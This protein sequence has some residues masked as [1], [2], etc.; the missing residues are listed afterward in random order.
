MIIN[1]ISVIL[2][3]LS[4]IQ[5]FGQEIDYGGTYSYG[6]NPESGPVGLI[7]VHPNSDS[8]LL[9]YLDLNIGSPS[10]NNGS[11]IGQM[12]IYSPGEA[13]F[14]IVNQNE[15]INCSM[16]FWFTN[17][18]LY[19]RTNDQADDCG[20]G[21]GVYSKGDF[22]R[23]EEDT[24]EFFINRNGKQFWFKDLDWKKWWTSNKNE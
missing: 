14:T 18:S 6:T 20:Y 11:I 8:T 1:R 19:I 16:N 24:P 13:D 5:V 17:D 12:N 9:F 23:I 2:I 4:S 3:F 22:R 7:S 21:H 15:F 10:Y